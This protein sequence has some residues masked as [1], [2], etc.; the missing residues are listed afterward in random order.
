MKSARVLKS[1]KLY[2]VTNASFLQNNYNT[3]PLET[4]IDNNLEKRAAQY[5]S[6]GFVSC[7]L[8]NFTSDGNRKVILI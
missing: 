2:P 3:T 5:S 7:L 4:N 8:D 6:S 1:A